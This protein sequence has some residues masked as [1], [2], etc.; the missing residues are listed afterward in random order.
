MRRSLDLISFTVG[1][2]AL[3]Q[4]LSLILG[5]GVLSPP[6]IVLLKMSELLQNPSMRE[7]IKQT[8]LATFSAFAITTVLGLAVGLVLG[9]NRRAGNIFEPILVATYSI[10]KIILYPVFLLIFG[11]TLSARVA[12]GVVHGIFPI[13]LFSLNSI[14]NIP[15]VYLRTARSL[16][17]SRWQ[18][19]KSIIFPAALPGIMN[20]VRIGTAVTLLGVVISEM[21]AARSGVGFRLMR[22]IELNDVPA[23][24]ALALLFTIFTITVNALLVYVSLKLTGVRNS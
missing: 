18:R 20:G 4:V 22:A 3:W 9:G 19:L 5:A 1:V 15:P 7:D 21:F 11:L 24:M 14:R 2:F 16:Q 8:L 17:M 23:I 6:L 10:P 12:F 13:I